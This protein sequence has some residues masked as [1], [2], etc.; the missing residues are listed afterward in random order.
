M[1]SLGCTVDNIP[2]GRFRRRGDG[3]C[4]ITYAFT[5][6]NVPFPGVNTHAYGIN[7]S[8][9]PKKLQRKKRQEIVSEGECT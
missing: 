9:S 6:I 7:D 8:G 1:K 4:G 3:T 5:A 2:D